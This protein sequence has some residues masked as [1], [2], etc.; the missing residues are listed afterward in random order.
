[1]LL[2]FEVIHWGDPAFDLGFALTHLLSKAHHL[3]P[4]RAR[5]AQA[6]N[7]YWSTYQAAL[8]EV[9]WHEGL[10]EYAVHHTLACLLPAGPAPFAIGVLNG[11]GTAD[12]KRNWSSPC[13]KRR[14]G[15][16]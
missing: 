1:M 7:H 4:Q 3:P 15:Q 2:D 13:C 12:I 6:A 8:G 11:G 16:S 5:F 9:A 10:E 14:R